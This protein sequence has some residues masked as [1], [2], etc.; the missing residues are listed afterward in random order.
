MSSACQ[1]QVLQERSHVIGTDQLEM[2]KTIADQIDRM[3]Q[4]VGYQLQRALAGRKTLQ[5]NTCQR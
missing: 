2:E 3:N 5:K 4:I 1:T